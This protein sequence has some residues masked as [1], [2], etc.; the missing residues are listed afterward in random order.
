V[1]DEGGFAPELLSN[2]RALQVIMDAIK[3]CGWDP[4]KH[5]YLGLDVAAS[6]F[7]NKGNYYLIKKQGWRAEKMIT[8]LENWVKKFPI[9]TIE[10]GLAEDDWDNWKI[11]TKELGRKVAL[12]G[13]DLFV[14]N[15][16][17]LERGIKEK[18]ANAILIKVNQIGTLSETIETILLAKKFGYQV[19]VSHR[20]GETSD[21]FIADLSVA[22]NAEYIKTGSLSRSERTEKYNRL[23]EIEE[24]LGI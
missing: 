10:D 21:A 11:L 23:M 22:V 8:T 20:S 18:V 3:Y 24:E 4:G 17:R 13:D 7:Y 16:D 9:A 1:G 15:V 12:V 19:A 2:E 14:T 5:V 6:E